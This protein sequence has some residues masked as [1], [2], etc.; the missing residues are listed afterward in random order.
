VHVSSPATIC[1]NAVCPIAC[2]DMYDAA[3][4]VTDWA[5][6]KACHF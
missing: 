2:L 3:Q 6:Y 4:S 5:E 1:E